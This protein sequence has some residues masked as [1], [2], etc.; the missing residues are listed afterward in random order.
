MDRLAELFAVVPREPDHIIDWNDIER[1]VMCLYASRMKDTRQNP[2]YHAEG[3]V[4]THTKMV[5]ECL[6][7]DD[8]Y[9]ALELRRRQ[10]LFLAALFHDVGKIY[11]TR[12][13]NGEWTSPD[14]AIV[15]A[16][17]VREMLWIEYGLSGTPELQ[18]IRE[19]ICMLVRYHMTVP[20]ILERK[21]PEYRLIKTAANGSLA[22][23]L[24][25]RMLLILSRADSNGKISEDAGEGEEKVLL[26][27]ELAAENDC[28]DGPCR[29]TDP[30]T[31]YAYLSGRKVTPDTRLY[32][33]SVCE[34][35]LMCGL[36]G[37]GKDTWIRENYPDRPVISLDAIR[38]E[39]GLPS[40]G[41][42]SEVVRI[43][44]KKAKELLRERRSF[45]W[46]ATS[47]T[48]EFRR[49][50]VELFVGYHAYVK[51]VF[52][53]TP[54]DEN[55]RRNL[56]RPFPVPEAVIGRMLAKLTPPERFEA[57]E[58]IWLCI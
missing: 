25:L 13:E 32:N 29:F 49:K 37:T 26:A 16:K 42:Q 47:V 57:H 3:D 54:W 44:H 51:I 55:L 15:G 46:N 50:P 1:T 33:D 8:D 18:N 11:T 23:D 21:D 53:E 12:M 34:V 48:R 6:V 35:I 43:A 36:P 19:T 5:C 17:A 27:R 28:L 9:R 56:D 39:Y 40:V 38:A 10:E 41:D 4:W 24:S 31:E 30:F 58:V 2:K 7:R 22:R 45:I 52:L 14:H 20:Y